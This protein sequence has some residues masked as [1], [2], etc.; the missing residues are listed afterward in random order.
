MNSGGRP[1]ML[2]R[3]FLLTAPIHAPRDDSSAHT[4]L[5]NV[6]LPVAFLIAKPTQ[7]LVVYIRRYHKSLKLTFPSNIFQG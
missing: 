3:N 2:D 1:L 6:T 7:S 5:T 4:G